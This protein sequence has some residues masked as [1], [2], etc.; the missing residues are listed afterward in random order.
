MNKSFATMKDQLKFLK[1]L[2]Q[3]PAGNNGYVLVNDDFYSVFP[4][5]FDEVKQILSSF[6]DKKIIDYFFD[7]ENESLYIK[8]LPK[9]FSFLLEQDEMMRRFRIPVVISI[10]ALVISAISIVISIFLR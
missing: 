9:G 1:I 3:T 10:V 4:F 2:M 8:I 7:E 6:D 5:S